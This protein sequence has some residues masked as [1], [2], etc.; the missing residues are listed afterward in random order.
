MFLILFTKPEKTFE[1]TFLLFSPTNGENIKEE[2]I[3]V[4]LP[5]N[6]PVKNIFIF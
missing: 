5:T 6:K 4:T 3:P 1:S 2:K